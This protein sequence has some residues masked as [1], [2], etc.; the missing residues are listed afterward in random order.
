MNSTLLLIVGSRSIVKTH[1]QPAPSIPTGGITM[2][3]KYG[4]SVKDISF[5]PGQIFLLYYYYY[6]LHCLPQWSNMLSDSFS[7]H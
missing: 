2:T 6:Y 3:P 4:K 5:G 1:V 7:D